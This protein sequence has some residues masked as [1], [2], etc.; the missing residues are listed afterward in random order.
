MNIKKSKFFILII[1]V[2]IIVV[3]V[4]FLANY[5]GGIGK[6]QKPIKIGVILPINDTFLKQVQM[7]KK[8]ADLAMEEI[9]ADGERKIELIYKDGGCEA[10][11]AELAAKELISR[12]RVNF[13]IG[14]FCS[15]ESLSIA[16]IAQ[17][18]SVIM[19]APA[20]AD[21]TLTSIGDY[22]FN[23]SAN[24]KV[25]GFMIARYLLSD[26]KSKKV[27]VIR[28]EREYASVLIEDFKKYFT[29]QE[30]KIAEEITFNPRDLDINEIVRQ[31]NNRNFEALI[32]VSEIPA[33]ASKIV[34]ELK[35][36]VLGN[37][38]F[39]SSKMFNNIAWKNYSE[40]ENLYV[41]KPLLEENRQREK[42]KENY[43]NKYD[44]EAKYLEEQSN[45]YSAVY[46]IVESV[47]KYDSDIDKVRNYF[48]ELKNWEHTLGK[49]SFDNQGDRVPSYVVYQV[50]NGELEEIKK[51]SP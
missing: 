35:G 1:A 39:L 3:G 46:L 23:L 25:E 18:N 50:K 14:G 27:A 31:L 34:S 37:K 42:F 4:Y 8:S 30:G 29:N 45:I 44:E 7:M 15:S 9:N 40:F 36:S 16:K 17:D 41:L 28:E 33:T 32:L 11:K 13:I 20:N 12:D 48:S 38:I 5:F 49:L 24:E 19:L 10:N 43:Q 26:L 51:Y 2:V 6:Y 47:K 21:P 22:I